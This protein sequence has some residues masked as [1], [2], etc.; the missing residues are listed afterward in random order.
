[1]TRNSDFWL[2]F[3][4]LGFC[5]VAS[6]LTIDVPTGG[7]GGTVGPN[8]LPWLM[9]GGLSLFALILLW[10]S[11]RHTPA[12]QAPFGARLLAQ[13]GGFLLL[14]LAYAWAYE[15]IGYLVSSVVFFVVALL[16]LGER[17]LLQLVLVPPAI[18]GAVYVVFT[19]VMQVYMP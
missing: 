18:V 12:A 4:V 11:Q 5:A 14:M 15:P 16:L 2:S 19:Y 10:R 6:A 9:I 13:L 17:R 8:F 3:V 7:T 1:M